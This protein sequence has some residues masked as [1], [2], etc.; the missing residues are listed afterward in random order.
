MAR[1]KTPKSLYVP[2]TW[3]IPQDVLVALRERAEAWERP[4]NTELII[5]LKQA[6]GLHGDQDR[7]RQSAAAIGD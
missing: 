6:L 5:C 7:P 3:R 1:P 4:V 2:I